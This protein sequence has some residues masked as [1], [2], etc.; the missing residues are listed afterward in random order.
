LSVTSASGQRVVIIGPGVACSRDANGCSGRG[1]RKHGIAA[2]VVSRRLGAG[3]VGKRA[4]VIEPAILDA[5]DGATRGG[6]IGSGCANAQPRQLTWICRA[7]ASAQQLEAKIVR[8]GGVNGL[9]AMNISMSSM[10]IRAG[11]FAAW[12]VA[13]LCVACWIARRVIGPGVGIGVVSV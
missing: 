7:R 2:R 13:W 9:V 6:G 3:V 12:R 11:V 1:V 4:V 8:R 5:S 10:S